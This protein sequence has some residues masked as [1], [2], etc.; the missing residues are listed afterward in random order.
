MTNFLTWIKAFLKAHSVSSQT[1]ASA[2]VCAVLLYSNNPAFHDYIKNAYAALPHG[3]HSFIAG[4]VIPVAIFWR[5]TH[6]TKVS[7]EVEDSS[8]G[9]AA[10]TAVATV[11][12]PTEPPAEAKK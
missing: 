7:A 8:G 10:A 6:T 4:I 5:T 1:I 3:L 11:P 9:S 2:W 12:E